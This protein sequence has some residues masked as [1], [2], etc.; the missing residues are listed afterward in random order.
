MAIDRE[1]MRTC[2]REELGCP[3]LTDLSDTMLN[4]A[5][6]AALEMYSKH[7]PRIE[8]IEVSVPTNG[9]AQADRDILTVIGN[10][11]SSRVTEGIDID[12]LLGFESTRDFVATFSGFGTNDLREIGMDAYLNEIEAE[13]AGI[14]LPNEVRLV[15][16]QY[17]F[18]PSPTSVTLATLRV[19]RLHTDATFPER[20]RDQLHQGAYARG[21]RS[22][23]M[24][25]YKFTAV[26]VGGEKLSLRSPDPLLKMAE[27]L[28]EKF[29]RSLIPL[30]AAMVVSS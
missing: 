11:W 5:I 7:H 12:N 27:E 21:M 17:E 2:L 10:S 29:I 1:A 26:N 13:R 30:R 6:D 16:N 14:N 19:G 4:C 20:H 9:I 18:M 23:A 15:G 22:L 3:S 28:W 8:D 25:R 24:R